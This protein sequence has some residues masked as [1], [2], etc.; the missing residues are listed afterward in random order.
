MPMIPIGRNN[1]NSDRIVNLVTPAAQGT[2]SNGVKLV[3]AGSEDLYLFGE[4]ADAIREW[5]K[6]TAKPAVV[7]K[8]EP[9][10]PIV[11]K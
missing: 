4:E 6:A 9:T 11:A 10:K 5:L 8:A 2:Q 1:I 7:T 3:L